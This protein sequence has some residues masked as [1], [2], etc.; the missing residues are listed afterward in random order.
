MEMKAEKIFQK[1]MSD[2]IMKI[3]L[4]RKLFHF[5]V[6]CFRHHHRHQALP[7]SISHQTHF[8]MLSSLHN[9]NKLFSSLFDCL[10]LIELFDFILFIGRLC[11]WM[12][13]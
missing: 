12:S 10:S 4:Q 2:K 9:K 11:V 6:A 13:G 5:Y 7:L 1:R 3:L 8:Y